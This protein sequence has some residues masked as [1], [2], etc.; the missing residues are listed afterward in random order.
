MRATSRYAVAVLVGLGAAVTSPEITPAQDRSRDQK[1][2]VM[3]EL[4]GEMLECSSYFLILAQCVESHPDPRAPKIAENYRHSAQQL[5]T[6]AITV[7]RSIGITDEATEA[8]TKLSFGQQ[9]KSIKNNC[10]NISVLLERYSDFCALMGRTP[11]KRMEE[12]AAGKFCTGT[13]KCQP[14]K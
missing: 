14:Q 6:L 8:R 12:L 7:G 11:D 2:D 4:A 10:I 9:M 13:Y 1:I 3:N 5:G